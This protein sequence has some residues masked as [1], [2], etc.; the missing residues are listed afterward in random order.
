MDLLKQSIINCFMSKKYGYPGIE[1]GKCAGLRTLNGQGEP[2][3]ECKKCS[4]QYQ[5]E[6]ELKKCKCGKQISSYRTICY[7]CAEKI[8][9]AKAKKI[10]AKDYKYDWVYDIETEEYFKID[11]LEEYY[12]ENEKILPKYVY[13]CIPIK[14]S[15]DM[16]SIVENELQ[17]N[18]YENA[19][20]D[21]NLEQLKKIQETVNEWTEFQNIVSWEQDN[22]LVILLEN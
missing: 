17:D 13:G 20:L 12:E 21:I 4:L 11:E 10:K 8:R 16:Y 15:L 5:Y 7:E 6:E 14:F 1:N 2:C 3:E 18:H 22:N 9:F 19:F